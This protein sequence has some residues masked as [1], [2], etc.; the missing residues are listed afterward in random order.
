MSSTM[1][2]NTT[3]AAIRSQ[4]R[5][6]AKYKER[7]DTT[8]CDT[9]AP[10]LNFTPPLSPTTPQH[11]IVY[12]G[13][14]MLERL[15]TTGT[16]T[17]LHRMPNSL[18]L[19]VGGDKLENV[20][21]RIDIGLWSLFHARRHAL[22]PEG[23]VKLFVLHAGT[24]NLR[25][26][27]GGFRAK[28]TTAYE[29]LIRALLEMGGGA[30]KVLCTGLFF[31]KDVEESAVRASNVEI[32]GVVTKLDQEFEGR[33]SYLAPPTEVGMDDRWLVDHVHLTAEGYRV[34]DALLGAEVKSLLE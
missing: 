3:A 5:E 33:V 23:E 10:L 13:D 25:A 11:K 12:I 27:R 15:K 16:S 2:A 19:G 28:E 26:P 17:T 22:F 20:L 1:T 31:R 29:L 24:N 6:V 4:I 8:H 9:H 34:W 21:Y 14:S 30:C 18:N 32:E 7:S